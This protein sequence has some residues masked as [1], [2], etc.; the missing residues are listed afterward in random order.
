MQRPRP[1]DSELPDFDPDKFKPGYVPPIVKKGDTE[2]AIVVTG[3][4]DTGLCGKY[5]SDID[6]L[7]R[8]RRCTLNE[9]KPEVVPSPGKGPVSMIPDVNPMILIV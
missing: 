6:N 2:Y 9:P 8:K 1:N 5:W 4:K 7:P 3:V